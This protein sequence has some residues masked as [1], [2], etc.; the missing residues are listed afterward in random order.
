MTCSKPGW[1]VAA[2]TRGVA[3]RDPGA[4]YAR[5]LAQHEQIEKDLSRVM[6]RWQKSK[7]RLKRA[8]KRLDSLV[9]AMHDI[10]DMGDDP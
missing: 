6:N 2:H 7:D 3:K 8:E 9:T 1:G 10:Q 4:R 5:L